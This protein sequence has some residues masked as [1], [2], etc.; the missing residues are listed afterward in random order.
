MTKDELWQSISEYYL[1]SRDF[2]GLPIRTVDLPEK[3]LKAIL[4]E[5]IEAGEVS[6]VFEEQHP[7]PYVKCLPSLAIDKQ[8]KLLNEYEDLTHVVA[9]P[10]GQRLAKVV[11]RR[12]Y[13][14][15]PYRLVVA[16]GRPSLD[17][18]YFKLDVLERYRNDPRYS[19]RFNDVVGSIYARDEDMG[20]E[21]VFIKSVGIAYDDDMNRAVCVFYTDLMDMSKEQQQ[22]WKHF[23]VTGTYNPHPEFTWSQVYGHFPEKA[24]LAEAITTEIK[25]INEL[26]IDCYG[27][28][29]FKHEYYD[30]KRPKELAFLIRPTAKELDAFIHI[31]D[32]IISENIN[33]KFFKG[34]V[35]PEIEETRKDGKIVVTPKGSL[36][37]L[38]EYIREWFKP[39][40]AKPMDEMFETFKKIRRLRTKP[41]HSIEEDD[42][43]MKYFKEQREL[44]IEAYTAMRFLRLILQ[45]HPKADR[46]KIPNWLYEGKIGT[47]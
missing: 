34:L 38:E 19:Y 2:N 29:L 21:E 27:K 23:E 31:L 16:L 36:T 39:A 45:N 30:S 20:K 12:R 35:K 33:K 43:N 46:K 1:N 9:Y 25:V 26:A 37:I 44:F 7:N 22:Y 3:E 8:V 32:K 24:S 18:A 15:K 13:T 47:Y 40:Y 6:L 4:I 28:K 14:G 5:L 17:C 41:A 42:F 10:E 11:K